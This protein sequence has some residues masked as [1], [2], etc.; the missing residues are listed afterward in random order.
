[1]PLK[2]TAVGQNLSTGQ[3][4]LFCMARA[5]LLRPKIL[6]LDEATSNIDIES[7]V[8]IQKLLLE[9]FSSS[10]V[11]TI[12]HRLDTIMGGDQILVLQL[13]CSFSPLFF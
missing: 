12:A 9:R 11:L 3:K 7:D 1:M 2:N 5:L 13:L 4:Q 6:V 10:T 8:V